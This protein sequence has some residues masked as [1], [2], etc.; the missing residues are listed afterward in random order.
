MDLDYFSQLT[1]P[2]PARTPTGGGG[3]LDPPGLGHPPAQCP[4]LLAMYIRHRRVA[5]R[6]LRGPRGA[7]VRG[8]TGARDV[9][10]ER[11]PRRLGGALAI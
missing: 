7:L 10:P 11:T 8:G 4:L 9:H 1:C 2:L 6:K 3:D 5:L